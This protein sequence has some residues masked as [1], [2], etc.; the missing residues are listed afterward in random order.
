MPKNHLKIEASALR[1]EFH[2]E[3]E[4]IVEGYQMTRELLIKCFE[5]QL[6][7]SYERENASEPSPSPNRDITHL[8][9]GRRQHATPPPLPPVEVEATHLSIVLSSEFYNKVC[10]L[11]RTEFESSIFHAVLDFE[12]ISRLHIRHDQAP[13]YQDHFR[14][15]KVLWRELTKAGRVAV[16]KDP[17]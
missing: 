14:I 6:L 12:H 3:T 4:N 7:A 11:D 16:R 17:K 1:L 2:G 9:H 15:G 5:E 13:F 8:L 10:V